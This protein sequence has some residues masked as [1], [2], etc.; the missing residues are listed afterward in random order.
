MIM[1]LMRATFEVMREELIHWWPELQTR[2]V[3]AESSQYSK[4]AGKGRGIALWQLFLDEDVEE[5][6]EKKPID[7]DVIFPI[8]SYVPKE[9]GGEMLVNGSL[10]TGPH[11]NF[12]LRA[13]MKLR[14][15]FCSNLPNYV[16][17]CNVGR[18][19]L[20]HTRMRFNESRLRANHP[21]CEDSMKKS[22][23]TGPHHARKH[24]N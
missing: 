23:W 22:G 13:P 11:H 5:I 2:M 9:A 21:T 6:P 18:H 16:S 12:R 3:T 8:G 24:S 1:Q 20:P 14:L 10:K 17:G 15:N 7:V 4:F 19:G